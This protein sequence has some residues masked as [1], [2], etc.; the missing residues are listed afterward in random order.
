[1]G[2]RRDKGLNENLARELLELHTLG[3]NAGYTQDDVTQVARILTD[4]T[5]DR[6]DPG[7]ARFEPGLHQPGS[8]TV[9]GRSYAEGPQA[10]DELLRD[11][12]RHPA[13]AQ[14]LAT[15]LARHFV[16]DDPP[17]ELVQAV[18]QRYTQTE[19]DLAQTA[20]A[21]MAHPL[22]WDSRW[23]PKFKRPEEWV[24]SAHRVLK[25]PL[26][27]AQAPALYG[28]L[29]ALGQTPGRAPSPQGW[30][31][32][33]EDWLSPEALLQRSRFAQ[34]FGRLQSDQ[35]DAR[36]VAELIWAGG[37]PAALRQ[38]LAGAPSNAQALALVLSS[39]EFMQR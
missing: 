6:D 19:G 16:T 23:P 22:T 35:A 34:R 24:L 9:L 10:L 5:L 3:V 1:V 25:L 36:A 31:D 12:A 17:A 11:L 33:S 14:H 7:Q 2:K 32:R 38:E 15:Q 27:P 26:L 4:W 28:A 30:P 8:K 39:P 37:A 29:T 20:Q 13:T 18:A 21:L